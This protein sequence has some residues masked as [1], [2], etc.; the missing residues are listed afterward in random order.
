MLTLRKGHTYTLG[1]N[2]KSPRKRKV[3]H[4]GQR[5]AQ[6]QV[7][8]ALKDPSRSLSRTHARLEFDEAAGKFVLKD[9]SSA[10]CILVNNAPVPTPHGIELKNGDRLSFS[11]KTNYEFVFVTACL[12]STDS[13]KE[14]PNATSSGDELSRTPKRR[15]LDDDR[16]VALWACS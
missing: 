1:R 11:A 12:G 4:A 9:L 16:Y 3:A 8:V 13:S 15:R 6:S 14:S 2:P 5:S 10:A 7:Y